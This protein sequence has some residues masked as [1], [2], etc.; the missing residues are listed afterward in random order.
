[1]KLKKL[2]DELGSYS[3]TTYSCGADNKRRKFMQFLIGF[4]DSYSV[5][6]GQLLLMNSL[7]DVT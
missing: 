6:R 7:S 1:M 4:N 3:N 2:W 5:I